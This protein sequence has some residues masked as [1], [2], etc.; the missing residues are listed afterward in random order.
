MSREEWGFLEGRWLPWPV[1]W[2]DYFGRSAPL[3]VEIGFGNG[4]F[5][6]DLAARREEANIVGVEISQPSLRSAQRK[7]S[8]QQRKNVLL[9]HALAGQALWTLCAPQSLSGVFIN[10]PDPWPKASHRSRRLIDQPFLS[11]LAARL[12]PQAM[13]D[14]ATDDAQY[15]LEIARHLASHQSFD[16]RLPTPY[17]HEDNTRLRTKYE[18]LSRPHGRHCYYFKWRR[19]K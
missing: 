6:L 14:I 2:H 8:S 4:Q 16:S 15:A 10:F 5:L 11:L 17:V 12:H 1:P 9:V 13:L 3:L 7:V 18:S 19:K